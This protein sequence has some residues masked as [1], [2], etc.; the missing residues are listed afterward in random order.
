MTWTADRCYVEGLD[1]FTA[2]V[3]AMGT[4][5]WDRPSPCARWRALD[6]LGHVGAATRFGTQLLQGLSPQWAPSA[7]APGDEVEGDPVAWWDALVE[8]AHDALGHVDLSRVVDSPRGKRSIGEGLSFP[9]V[10]LFVHG[11][12]LARTTGAD[13]E[14]PAEA[15]EFAHTVLDPIPPDMMRSATV[16]ATAID[17]GPDASASNT[18]LAWTGRDPRGK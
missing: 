8:P 18:F 12:D 17:I 5:D 3:H 11:W 10:D 6:V 4:E 2:R 7:G 9:A 16:F 13:V 15:I 1:F 14:I